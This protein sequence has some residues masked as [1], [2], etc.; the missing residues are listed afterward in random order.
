MVLQLLSNLA[1][2]GGPK[3]PK[4]IPRR[5]KGIHKVP[6]QGPKG[7]FRDLHKTPYALRSSPATEICV[8]PKD[9]RLSSLHRLSMQIPMAVAHLRDSVLHEP[10]KKLQLMGSAGAAK[11]LQ[12]QGSAAEGRSPIR[13]PPKGESGV[14]DSQKESKKNAVLC[15]H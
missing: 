5:P 13:R 1:H 2:Q 7:L 10:P 4:S 6:P 3:D 8:F 9:K 12:F 15:M 14:L 11:R